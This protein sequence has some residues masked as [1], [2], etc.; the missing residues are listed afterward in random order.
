[1]ATHSNI[2]AWRVPWTEEPGGL[3]SLELQSQTRPSVLA[4]HNVCMSML[5][6]QFIPPSPY[7]LCHKSV[8][9]ISVF[10]PTLQIVLL[11]PF[12]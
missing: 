5:L 11:V 8:V 1:M 4:K 9:Y 6:S 3:Q 2:L 10:L 7:P 12:F